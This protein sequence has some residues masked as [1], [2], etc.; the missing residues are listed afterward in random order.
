MTKRYFTAMDYDKLIYFQMPKVLMYAEKY[1]NLGNDAKLLYMVCFD[2]IKVSMTN[3]GK[4]D[5]NGNIQCWK[6]ENGYFIRLSLEKIQKIMRCGKGKAVQLK[7]KLEKYNLLEQKRIGLNKAN[8]LYVMQLEYTKEDICVINEVEESLMKDDLEDDPDNIGEPPTSTESTE[9]RK[10]DFRKFE[11]RTSG[12]SKIGLQEVR[13]SDPINNNINK[14]KINNNNK[15]KVE[16]KEMNVVVVNNNL[17]QEKES[18]QVNNDI[19]LMNK[20]IGQANSLNIP[21]DDMLA[22]LL[23]KAGDKD[24]DRI[25]NALKAA[26]QWRRGKEKKKEKIENWTGVLIEAVKNGWQPVPET[27]A[28]KNKISA[29][30]NMTSKTN[31]DDLYEL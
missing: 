14:N 2:L 12:S 23:L 3:H 25:I 5:K 16:K 17:K 6:D 22:D 13:K 30:W 15:E 7:Q 29:T 9:V 28:G 1:K 21:M 31:L 10:S 20:I 19:E 4:R 11:N 8:L 27:L 26:D 24:I 18:V